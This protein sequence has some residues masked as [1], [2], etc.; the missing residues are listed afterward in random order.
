MKYFPISVFYSLLS[1]LSCDQNDGLAQP[2]N[3]LTLYI[4]KTEAVG[5]VKLSEPEITHI[6]YKNINV[7]LT[8][9]VDDYQKTH[10]QADI[11]PVLFVEKARR[12][13][14]VYFC[15]LS[16]DL[17]NVSRPDVD[18]RCTALKEYPVSL[19]RI[20]TGTKTRFMDMKTPEGE[21]Y[22]TGRNYNGKYYKSITISY[23]TPEVADTWSTCSAAEARDQIRYLDDFYKA[24]HP[25]ARNK[26]RC[27]S[28]E[29][30][31]QI[32]KAH[33]TC[34]D[35]HGSKTTGDGVQ[36]HGQGGNPSDNWTWGC[37]AVDNQYMD[38]LFNPKIKLIQ[39]GCTGL[40]NRARTKIIIV[41]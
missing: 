12:T 1:A 14:S 28:A 20:P 2:A 4:N 25:Q 13:L 39:T 40:K 30:K 15:N 41:P 33:K 10:P 31:R 34:S 19:G 21:F 3:E 6:P 24:N 18:D 16:Q 35:P 26:A 38:E 32:N 9:L 22:V 17:T 5:Q 37:V 8:T 36:I 23:P 11:Q 27:L 29:Q 7:P